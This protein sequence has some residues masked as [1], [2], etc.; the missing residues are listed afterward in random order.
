MVEEESCPKAEAPC[1]DSRVPDDRGRHQT[2]RSEEWLR[3]NRAR[4]PRRHAPTAECRMTEDGTRLSEAK[5][6]AGGGNRTHTTLRSPDFES[7]A[8][9][10]FTTPA[11]GKVSGLSS[12]V[13]G[14]LSLVSRL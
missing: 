13:S 9:A 10:S 7:G 6:G 12:K 11:I 5:D 1:A 3:R 14:L 8:S 4:R 2:E